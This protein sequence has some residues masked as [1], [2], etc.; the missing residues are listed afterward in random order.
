[1]IDCTSIPRK[2]IYVGKGRAVYL[3]TFNLCTAFNDAFYKDSFSSS[4]FSTQR[5]DSLFW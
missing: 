1:M 3:S 2:T 4:Q 5:Y